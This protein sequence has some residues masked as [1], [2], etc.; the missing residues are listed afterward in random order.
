MN[1]ADREQILAQRGNLCVTIIIPTHGHNVQRIQNQKTIEKTFLGV[2]EQ[3]LTAKWP[4]HE[5]D[6]VSD[7]LDAILGTID[8]LRLQDGLAIFVSPKLSMY[9]LLPFR[10]TEKI[11]IE[12]NFEIRDLFYYQQFL[13]PYYLLALSKK[14][15][16]LFKCEGRDVKEVINNDFPRPYIDEYEYAKPSIASSSSQGL[17]SS[18][19]DKSILKESREMAFLLQTDKVLDSYLRTDMPLLIAGTREVLA[20]F[21]D[22]THH[23][24]HVIGSITG[25]YEFDALYPLAEAAWE[26]MEEYV[27]A[28]HRGTL[29]QLQEARGKNLVAEGL[30]E[31]WRAANEGKGLTLVLEKDYKA[32]AWVDPEDNARIYLKAPAGGYKALPDAVD[33]L[34]EIVSEKKGNII[35]V[36]NGSMQDQDPVA[37]LL[38]YSK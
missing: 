15:I 23:S 36:E 37:M 12:D 29:V 32:A 5:K 6:R 16:R 27:K 19:R 2:K 14:K 1:I 30:R 31:V 34:I 18:E 24:D 7:R 10:V 20:N 22:V 17:K 11:S 21:R 38:R 13:K 3:L 26:K 35:M 33:E 4:K 9:F 8:Y 28:S 25:S